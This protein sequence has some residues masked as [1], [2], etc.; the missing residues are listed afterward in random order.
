MFPSIKLPKRGSLGDIAAKMKE[1][2]MDMPVPIISSMK[3]KRENH[4]LAMRLWEEHANPILRGYSIVDEDKN[5]VLEKNVRLPGKGHGDEAE[6]IKTKAFASM[7]KQEKM[8]YREEQK[9]KRNAEKKVAKQAKEDAKAKK[10]AEKAHKK[11]TK[12][13][14]KADQLLMKSEAA[15]AKELEA[16]MKKVSEAIRTPA[17]APEDPSNTPT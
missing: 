12:H 17:G 3:Q 2:V 10:I 7:N 4:E 14:R 11:A 9:I 16:K 15:A 8:V 6:A 13:D 5:G 1:G